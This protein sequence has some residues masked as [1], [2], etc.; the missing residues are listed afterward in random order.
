MLVID[1]TDCF[2]RV[3][4]KQSTLINEFEKVEQVLTDKKDEIRMFAVDDY[5]FEFVEY[6]SDA[7]K[8]PCSVQESKGDQ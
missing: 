3:E 1:C 5:I 6:I 2:T 7:I 4:F 8:S